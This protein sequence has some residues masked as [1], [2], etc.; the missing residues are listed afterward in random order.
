MENQKFKEYQS[1]LDTDHDKNSEKFSDKNQEDL[2]SMISGQN[3]SETKNLE[4]EIE[5]FKTQAEKI[6]RA[7][8]FMYESFSDSVTPRLEFSHGVKID[9][10]TMTIHLDTEFFYKNGFNQKQMLWATYHELAHFKDLISDP[11]LFMENFKH[12]RQKAEEYGEKI[13]QITGQPKAILSEEQIKNGEVDPAVDQ[14]Y[15]GWHTFY[16]CLD[17]I[18]VNSLVERGVFAYSSKGPDKE[19]VADLYSRVLFSNT[20]YF[21]L[22]KSR[23]FSYVM[24]RKA[25]LPEQDL[26]VSPEIEE[27]LKREIIFLGKKITVEEMIGM[28]K[29]KTRSGMK[30]GNR[31]YMIKKTLEPIFEE[32]YNLDLKEWKK[33]REQKQEQNKEKQ[34]GESGGSSKGGEQNQEGSEDNEQKK[35]QESGD[36]ASEKKDGESG[37]SNDPDDSNESKESSGAGDPFDQEFDPKKSQQK[38]QKPTLPGGSHK[39][40]DDKE[41]NKII[42]QIKKFKENPGGELPKKTKEELEKERQ[43]QIEEQVQKWCHEN[44]IDREVLRRFEKIKSEISPYLAKLSKVWDS[45]ISGKGVNFERGTMSS[46]DGEVNVSRFIKYFPDILAG[47]IREVRPMDKKITKELPSNQ[48]ETI[49]VR[50]V[51]DASGSMSDGSVKQEVLEKVYVLI[52]MSLRDFETKLNR[53]RA[54]N[55]SKLSVQTEGW[56]FGSDAFKIKEFRKGKDYESEYA[57]IIRQFSRLRENLGYTCDSRVYKKIREELSSSDVS[58]IKSGKIMDLV[59]EVTDG[60][61]TDRSGNIDEE[62]VAQNVSD[63]EDVGT[64]VRAFQIGVVDEESRQIFERTWNNKKK[65]G[66]VVE[67]KVENLIP[68]IT[69]AL[70]QYLSNV[71]I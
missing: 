47:R 46:N 48:P 52:M 16:N 24:L 6:L 35:E 37:E 62:T 45:I 65:R 39:P 7:N 11:V 14:A 49:R 63:L 41:I 1:N 12:I 43:K 25:M 38:K 56:L 27:V 5:E 61:P 26:E 22:P 36:S 17:D 51:G 30:A 59:L 23:Q 64:V 20:K 67:D 10:K 3:D 42:E 28:I 60:V 53:T 50:F 44:K 34:N 9:F 68:K 31:Y 71:K 19:H 69:E 2:P 66:Y 29:S 21:D 33:R 15:D 40:I 54:Q 18:Y 8:K 13:R 57:Q 4:K 70:A 32:L 58:S 55:R